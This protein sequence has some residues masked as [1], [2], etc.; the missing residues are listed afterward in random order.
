MQDFGATAS[1][2]RNPPGMLS[3]SDL[4]LS[5]AMQ[6]TYRTRDM[7]NLQ[8]FT[9]QETANSFPAPN[10]MPKCGIA[11][12]G[13]QRSSSQRLS[14]PHEAQHSQ[15]AAKLS[16]R[17]D[18]NQGVA[19]KP[20][21]KSCTAADA[22]G[23]QELAEPLVQSDA[24]NPHEDAPHTGSH[25]HHTD[26]PDWLPAQVHQM[27]H[28]YSVIEPVSQLLGKELVGQRVAFVLLEEFQQLDARQ[29]TDILFA[30]LH[31]GQYAFYKAVW[32]VE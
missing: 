29:G 1:A 6:H 5:H 14:Q 31:T 25:A 22:R 16:Q 4:Q 17:I 7:T 19:N 27:Q 3:S 9:T 11:D 28:A 12:Q 18:A 24:D 20:L 23:I 21:S 13:L 32:P 30:G 2:L 15:P 26:C 10:Q 8:P